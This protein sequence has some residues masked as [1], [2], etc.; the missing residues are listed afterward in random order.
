MTELTKLDSVEIIGDVLNASGLQ[1]I[2]SSKTNYF[3]DQNGSE[4][5]DG[6]FKVL[7]KIIRVIKTEN[8]GSINLLRKTSLSVLD[9]QSFELFT[10]SLQDANTAGLKIPKMVT[11]LKGPLIQVIP[12]SIFT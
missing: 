9:S 12:I 10:K 11:E 8:E 5:I 7:G 2:L 4:I 6:E 3:L 1:A